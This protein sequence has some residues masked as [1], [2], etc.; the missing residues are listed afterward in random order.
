M[1]TPPPGTAIQALPFPRRIPK[2]PLTAVVPTDQ[3]GPLG[4]TAM[5]VAAPGTLRKLLPFQWKIWCAEL[6]IQG[7]PPPSTAMRPPPAAMA[8]PPTRLAAPGGPFQG[9]N[10]EPPAP[11]L[12]P[13]EPQGAVGAHANVGGP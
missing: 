3:A 13:R 1:R 2:P 8:P 10:P 12:G 7:L 5:S 6:R 11:R 9:E 4:P